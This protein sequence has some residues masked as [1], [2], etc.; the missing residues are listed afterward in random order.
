M[1]P[2]NE[3]PDTPDQPDSDDA[4]VAAAIGAEAAEGDALAGEP[5]DPLYTYVAKMNKPGKLQQ[6]WAFRQYSDEEAVA[7]AQAGTA[8]GGMWYGWTISK[9]MRINYPDPPTII[10]YP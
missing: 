2:H 6:S 7:F 8:P 10:P 3:H 4:A 5:G 9:L 1:N